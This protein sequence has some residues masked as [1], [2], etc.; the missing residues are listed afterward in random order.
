MKYWVKIKYSQAKPMDMEQISCP[1][2]SSKN[3]SHHMDRYSKKGKRVVYRCNWCKRIFVN[4]RFSRMRLKDEYI[5]M[6]LNLFNEGLSY[7]KIQKKL[8]DRTG[9]RIVRSTIYRWIRK[10][11]RDNL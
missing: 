1:E 8:Y 9:K 7:G 10:Y 4:E 6:A 3:V 5:I 2:C 11:S